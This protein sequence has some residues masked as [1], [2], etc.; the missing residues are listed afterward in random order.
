MSEKHT[1]RVIIREVVVPARRG[2]AQYILKF[3][4]GPL[5]VA[6]LAIAVLIGTRIFALFDASGAHLLEAALLGKAARFT[7]VICAG[8]SVVADQY[9]PVRA[10]QRDPEP[11]RT[12]LSLGMGVTALIAAGG[13]TVNGVVTGAAGAAL[14]YWILRGRVQR[15]PR[16]PLA[17]LEQED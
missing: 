7:A 17:G 9:A 1:E 8:W 13:W 2:A 14:T 6:A 11:T 15:A 12:L 5:L 4:R 10:G 3:L 16:H